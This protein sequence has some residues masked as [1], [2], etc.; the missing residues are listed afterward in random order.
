MLFQLIAA[1]F[2]IGR[3]QKKFGGG[4]FINRPRPME[5]LLLTDVTNKGNDFVDWAC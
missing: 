3:G 2:A 5:R 1:N 4:Q